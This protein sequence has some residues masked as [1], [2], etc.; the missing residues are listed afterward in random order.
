[1]SNF[2]QP[3]KFA[4]AERLPEEK[5][6]RQMELFRKN[7]TLDEF[8]SKIP[9][10]FII[11]NN[12][13]QIVYMNQGA[14]EFTGLEDYVSIIGERPGE[15]LG[16]IHS[17]EEAG[18]CGTSEACTYCGAVNAIL[19]SQKGKSV[20]MEARLILRPERN[21]YDLRIWA[22]PLKIENENFTALTIQDISHEKRRS[23][24]EHI[25]FH[26]II[27]SITGLFSTLQ[28]LADY[29]EMVDQK[30]LINRAYQMIQ[31]LNEE[32]QSHQ[33]LNAAEHNTYT[34]QIKKFNCSDILKDLTELSATF[35]TA[36]GKQI[37]ID[38]NSKDLELQSD[39]I[40]FRRII[41][42]MLKNALEATCEGDIITMGCRSIEDKVEIWVHNPGFIPRD[43]Q[44]QI[45]QRSFST[46][47]PNRGLGTYSMKLLSF[48]LGGNVNFETSKQEG[49]TFRVIIPK[50]NE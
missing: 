50:S 32:I 42:N 6:K 22:S 37:I 1:M 3:T 24:L 10:V 2:R 33:I 27:N 9:A 34:L 43:V 39:K 13:R 30:K 8:L 4:P 44:L 49:T 38:E 5:L 31:N 17:E 46:K 35:S 16:C 28:I 15:L 36:K 29:G 18:G 19:S 26:D 14:L 12:Y 45:F 47:S 21:A 41:F 11:V 40:L 20:M 48:L 25:F 23:A 7:I